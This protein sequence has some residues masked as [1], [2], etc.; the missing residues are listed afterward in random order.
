MYA[1][2]IDGKWHSI[3]DQSK[4]DSCGP[5]CVRMLVKMIANKDV[6][7]ELVR[8]LIEG[9]EGQ[10]AVSTIT[11]ERGGAGVSG[12]HNWGGHGGWG[13]GN[14][15]GGG[16]WNVVNT[17]KGLGVNSARVDTGYVRNA[18][19]NTSTRRPGMAVV[20]WNGG[21]NAH[22]SQGLHWVVVAGPVSDGRVLVLDPALGLQYADMSPAIVQYTPINGSLGSFQQ[23]TVL[24]SD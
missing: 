20:G 3:I 21:W 14:Q 9:D 10:A 18:F 13:G 6:G 11:S 24:T 17:L 19:R 4:T 22:G 12:S 1:R 15:F 23:H 8:S 7:E 16:T 2:D 5:A